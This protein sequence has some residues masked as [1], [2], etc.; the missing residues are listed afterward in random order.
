[1]SI[2]MQEYKSNT[3]VVRGETKQY[4]DQLKTFGGKWNSNLT[5]AT[6][7]EKFGAWI[8]FDKSQKNIISEWVKNVNNNPLYIH[9]FNQTNQQYNQQSSQYQSNQQ[10]NQQYTQPRSQYS[11][12]DS[13]NTD[14]QTRVVNM[15]IE[16][17]KLQV[18]L[19]AQQKQINE[20]VN[21]F[22][23]DISTDEDEEQYVQHERLLP[24]M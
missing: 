7:G 8:F 11:A 13:T 22:A 6:T 14:L 1:M 3:Y 12:I 10:Y 19:Q 24:R 2:C 20:L 5:D 18:Q 23:M 21:K 9:P 4:M 16:M 17:R 15:E